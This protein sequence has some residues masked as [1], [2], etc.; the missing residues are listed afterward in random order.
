MTT[1]QR[2]IPPLPWSAKYD[3]LFELKLRVVAKRIGANPAHLAACIAFETG[4]TFDPAK[5]N[6]AG[7][8]GTGLIQFMRA[9][10]IGIGTTVEALAAMTAVEQLVYVEKYF[11][12]YAGR[13]ST[14]EDLYMA[15]LYPK[16]VGKPLH[17]VL[18][19]E[20][21]QA[22]R[23]NS[24]LDRNGDG[25]VTKFEAADAVRRAY[26]RGLLPENM[27]KVDA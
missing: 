7:S 15:I 12:P 4:Y 9:T 25:Y 17:Y 16:A 21:T 19:R 3:C 10:A 13:L 22:Y 18:F 11:R 1:T 26:V 8:S 24:G 14:I 6:A 5:K 23:M 27:R 20:G 2:P